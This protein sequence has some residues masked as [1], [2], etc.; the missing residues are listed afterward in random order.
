LIC[1]A[2]APL[3][4]PPPAGFMI[5]QNMLWLT[6]PPPLFCTILRMSSGMAVRCRMRSSGDFV[7]S[8]GCLSMAPLRLVT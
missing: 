5:C 7:A 4:G 6:W 2:I 3:G 8:S 1:A